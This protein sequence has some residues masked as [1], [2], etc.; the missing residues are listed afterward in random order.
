MNEFILNLH[1][2]TPISD[3]EGTY[4]DILR[5]AAQAGIDAV[6][7]TDH[8]VWVD[9]VEKI[10]HTENGQV[11]LLVGEEVH[12]QARKPQK[13]HLLVFDARK[14]LATFA[15]DPQRLIQEVN[16]SGG[17]C[18]L[19]HPME[20]D[21]PFFHEPDISWVDWDVNG[22]TGIELWNGLSEF[23]A[24]ARTKLK[25][26]FYGFFPHFIAHG[27]P[28]SLLQ[29]WDELTRQDRKIVCIGGADA[30]AL[31]IH[32]G[33]IHRE[34]FPYLFH[35]RAVN[36]HILCE[37]V[38]NT[39]LAQ[40]RAQIYQALRSGHCFVGYDLPHPTRGF[41]FSARCGDQSVVMGDELHL[42][43]EVEFKI[44]LPHKAD[45]RLIKDGETI[46]RWTD[47]VAMDLSTTQSG[48]YRVECWIRYLGKTRGWIFSNPIYIKG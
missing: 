4:D 34:I 2:H 25:A 45:C 21:L 11:I 20:M 18:F 33:P 44:R 5:A 40:S 35:F 31:K 41:N 24:V 32:L 30:H 23:K 9:G 43:R 6:I 8:N 22:Y 10:L 7:V 26:L 47:Q 48:V 13:N 19:A 14:E 3:G 37:G 36:T 29:K 17:L 38:L 46:A 16:K 12:D 27:P 15:R 28:K 1:M 39:D 42:L